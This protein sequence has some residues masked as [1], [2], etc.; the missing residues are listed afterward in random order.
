MNTDTAKKIAIE[1][2]E[3]MEKYVCEFMEEW[4]GNK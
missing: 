4:N 2:T 1:R 3:F